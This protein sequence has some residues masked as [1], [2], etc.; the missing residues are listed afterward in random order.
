MVT[1]M[2]PFENQTD[3]VAAP[4]AEAPAPAEKPEPDESTKAYIKQWTDRI[5][6]AKTW[7]DPAFKRMRKCQQIAKHGDMEDWTGKNNDSG[8]Y[9]VPIVK[10]HINQSVA[11]LYAKNPTSY[12]ERKKRRMGQVWDGKMSTLQEA[13]Q[14]IAAA[15]EVGAQP[16]PNY[17]ALL[18][19]A[20]GVQQYIKMMDGL[21]E[22][23]NILH[24][25]FMNEQAAGYKQQFKALVRRTKVNGVAY[26]TLGFQRMLTPNPDVT[27]QIAD[28]TQQIALVEQR[29]REAGRDA[30]DEDSAK[31]E[32][33]KH[34]LADLQQ[35]EYLIAREGP[36]LGFP[37]STSIIIDP[38]VKHLKTLA[39]AGWWVEQYELSPEDIEKTYKVDVTGKFKKYAADKDAKPRWSDKQGKAVKDDLAMVW[40]V[41]DKNSGLEF[42]ICEGFD[43]YLK[44]PA[45]PDVRIERFFTL[46][47]LVFNEI[48][49][50]DE[51]IPPSDV[52]DARDTQREYNQ[53]RH[54][55]RE[56]RKQNKPGYYSPQNSLTETDKGRLMNRVSG[57]VVEVGAL[58]SGEK[59]E[60][61][62]APIKTVGID[63]NLYEVETLY[64]DMLRT[65]GSQQANLGGTGGDTATETSIAENSRQVS[66]SSNIDDLD[67]MLTELA[68]SMG[69]LM[70][71][72]LSKDTV[73]EI[74]GPGAVWPDMPQTREE[75]AKDLVLSIKAGSSGRPNKAA[76][77]ANMER[78]M[79][80]VLQL[81][82]VNPTP[83]AQDYLDLLEIDAEDRV[84]EGMPSI[85]A[86][87]AMAGRAATAQ[88]GAEPGKNPNEQGDEGDDNAPKPAGNEPGP[89]PAFTAP[90]AEP[91]V[92][93]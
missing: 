51:Q 25:Y 59:L 14:Q 5:R 44:A 46:Y 29:L 16:D 50:E 20:A 39:G 10:R 69:Q 47:P 38:A 4:V 82:G 57:E 73:M 43:N 66:E 27:A 62:L 68:R 81:P 56:H 36:V 86:L 12:A 42:T 53:A 26:V 83:I 55:L 8:K 37:G 77:L 85:N 88:Q 13:A 31:L 76:K 90:Q 72:E 17:L 87:N 64:N 49:D 92:L 45:C 65:V 80:Y 75:V 1:A 22:T 19:D 32:E 2:E 35:K 67:D 61:K 84:I 79:P 6:N 7:Y 41:Q 60:D 54:G 23:L 33:L 28:S 34:A 63:P 30:L 93:A 58:V 40:K 15:T 78:G 71:L 3:D 48:E 11:Q 91:G 89:Q 18:Q 9:V 24:E 21:A 52:W 74:V 70:L